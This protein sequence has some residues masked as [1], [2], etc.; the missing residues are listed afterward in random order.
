MEGLFKFTLL[1]RDACPYFVDHCSAREDNA[2]ELP[3]RV[4]Q[5]GL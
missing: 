5:R 1:A 2:A 4:E 3:K